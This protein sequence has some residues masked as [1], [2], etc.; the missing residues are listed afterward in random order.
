MSR[1]TKR[2]VRHYVEMVIA[3]YLGM[4]LLL[5]FDGLMWAF[6]IHTGDWSETAPAIPLAEM[7]VVMT[8]PMV[9]W[10]RYRGHGR[11]SCWEMAA[12]MIIPT[13]AALILLATGLIT[14]Y[15]ALMTVEHVAMFPGMLIAM[16]MR[17]DEYTCAH[18]HR[19]V[20]LAAEGARNV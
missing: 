17:P 13:V 8:L 18:H 11:R 6:G 1:Q 12:S 7:G 4:A 3:M 20:V 19:S 15:H 9:A 14:D 5:P 2:F 16:L 10:M